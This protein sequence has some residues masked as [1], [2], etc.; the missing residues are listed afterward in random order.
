MDEQLFQNLLISLLLPTLALFG[1][2]VAVG[3]DPYLKRDKKRTLLL[4]E[5]IVLAR[6]LLLMGKFCFKDAHVEHHAGH[7]HEPA[8]ICFNLCKPKDPTCLCQDAA[9]QVGD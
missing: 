1:L 2:G 4:I 6:D 8:H 7:H 3:F 5:A 9:L